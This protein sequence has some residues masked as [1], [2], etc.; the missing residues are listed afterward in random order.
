ME[1]KEP[2]LSWSS[3]CLLLTGVGYFMPSVMQEYNEYNIACMERDLAKLR[4]F[5]KDNEIKIP[6]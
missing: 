6:Q 4:Q 2:Y 1:K 5:A 3:T